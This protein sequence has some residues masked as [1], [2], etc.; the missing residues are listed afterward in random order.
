MN[1][2]DDRHRNEKKRR[3]LSQGTRSELSGERPDIGKRIQAHHLQKI[4][5]AFLTKSN[6]KENYM[7]LLEGEHQSFHDATNSTHE[8]GKTLAARQSVA[9]ELWNKPT[10]YRLREK[11]S[12]YDEILIPEFIDKVMNNL[13]KRVSDVFIEKMMTGAYATNRELMIDL[14]A[15]ELE[16]E[17]L[18]EEIQRL[19]NLTNK[20]IIDITQRRHLEE[21]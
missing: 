8:G 12:Q 19:R 14:R 3:L 2:Y 9:R 15:A 20:K 11:L 16:I 7:N 13:P 1:V 10:D 6:Y 17:A 5:I 21:M 18:K 4:S